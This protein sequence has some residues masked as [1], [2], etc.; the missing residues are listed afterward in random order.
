MRNKGEK[1]R[2]CWTPELIG[3]TG[4][5]KVVIHKYRSRDGEER[6][7]NRIEKLYPAYDAPDLQSPKSSVPVYQPPVQGYQP[8]KG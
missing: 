6:E 5:C 8:K 4:V 3:K 2:M 1:L 7:T